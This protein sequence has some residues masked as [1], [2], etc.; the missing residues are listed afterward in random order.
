MQITLD[1]LSQA[2]GFQQITSTLPQG[3]LIGIM[4]ANGAGKSTLLQTIAGI[5]PPQTG[6][7][8][9]AGVPLNELTPTQKSQSLAYLAQNTQIYWD[10]P[11]SE[12]IALGLTK[13]LKASQEQEKVAHWAAR[14]AVEHL[15]H[16]PFMQL[17]GGERARVQLARC[18]IKEAPL[19]LADEPIAALDP[20]Y[21]IDMLEQLKAL[22]PAQTCILAIH[23]LA[24]AYQFC[25]WILLL[26]QGRLLAAG[27]TTEVLTA[28]N[29]AQA[30]AVKAKLEPQ[31]RQLSH[32]EKL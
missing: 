24:L 8:R 6:T 19:L 27:E 9:F 7:V 30:F 10:L 12:V 21:Q 5:L 32:I 29:L 14:F 2:Y 15:L 16:K 31:M 28:E 3:K 26:S 25:D 20:Y 13:P 18:A 1:N 17:S 23:H 4:G 22:T 11:V